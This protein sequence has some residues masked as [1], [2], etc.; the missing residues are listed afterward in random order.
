MI[1]RRSMPEGCRKS[2][3]TACAQQLLAEALKREYGIP[4]L[5]R[6]ERTE[7]GKPYFADY[8]EIHFNYSHC[9]DVAVCSLS[10]ARTGIDIEMIRPFHEWTARIFCSDREWGWLEKQTDR[11]LAWIRIWTLKEAYV[12]YTGSGIRTDLSRL[13]MLNVLE[14]QTEQKEVWDHGEKVILY[15]ETILC[16]REQ[17]SVF[18][19][20]K[21][22]KIMCCI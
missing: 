5:P 1:Y 8:P 6:I 2:E 15:A 14:N 22:N 11:D 9:R 7:K 13:D 10:S 12:K 18:C 16:G 3:Q 19:E 20:Q 4:V 17:I 21:I